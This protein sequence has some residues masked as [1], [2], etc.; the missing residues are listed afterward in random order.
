MKIL[1]YVAKV[2]SQK[3]PV[4]WGDSAVGGFAT[5]LATTLG[6][7]L[8]VRS[9]FKSAKPPNGLLTATQWLDLKRLSSGSPTPS[10]A[11]KSEMLAVNWF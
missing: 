11:F 1:D 7:P 3:E 4:R 8:R 6:T 5:P 2:K 9:S 10:L